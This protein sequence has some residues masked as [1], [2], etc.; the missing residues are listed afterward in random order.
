MFL[1]S[2]PPATRGTLNL[3]CGPLC[4]S[5]VV[6]TVKYRTCCWTLPGEHKSMWMNSRRQTDVLDSNG[7]S[8]AL[9]SSAN[10]FHAQMFPCEGFPGVQRRTALRN[11]YRLLD[12]SQCPFGCVGVM[13][14][15]LWMSSLY[16]EVWVDP[17][18]GCAICQINK[19]GR[20]HTKLQ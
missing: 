2:E 9:V 4:S 5:E 19:M 8:Q 1:P 3:V 18:D 13:L 11:D 12:G 20:E 15:S 17:D 14:R 7:L 16:F 6:E 10:C